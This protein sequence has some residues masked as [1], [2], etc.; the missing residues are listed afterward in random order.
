LFSL[1]DAA[2]P[3][4]V[5]GSSSSVRVVFTSNS[6]SQGHTGFSASWY[7]IITT[8]TVPSTLST[9]AEVVECCHKAALRAN[10]LLLA[11]ITFLYFAY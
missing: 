1:C 9:D 3:V 2:V 7:A 4:T 8:S 6:S 11:F 5:T 10:L